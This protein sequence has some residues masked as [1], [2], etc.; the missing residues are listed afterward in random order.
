MNPNYDFRCL[1]ANIV[2]E[3][4]IDNET[5]EVTLMLYGVKPN[6]FD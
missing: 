3:I 6:L 5:I 1:F 4:T 2:E